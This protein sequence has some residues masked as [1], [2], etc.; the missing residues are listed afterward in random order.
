MS[1][2]NSLGSV[3]IPRLLL[4]GFSGFGYVSGK[5][6]QAEPA[7]GGWITIPAQT[8]VTSDMVAATVERRM[9]W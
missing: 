3:V 4:V 9:L 5:L 6:K 2:A 8:L 7:G 1:L